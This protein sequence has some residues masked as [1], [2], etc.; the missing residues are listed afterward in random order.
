MKRMLSPPAPFQVT[1][2]TPLPTLVTYRAALRQVILNLI[3]NACEAMNEVPVESRLLRIV[4]RAGPRPGEIELS[5]ADRG[6]GIAPGQRERIFQPFITTKPDGLGLGLAICRSIVRAHGG[7]LWAETAERGAVFR[8][9]LR[10]SDLFT[11]ASA[12][13]QPDRGGRAEH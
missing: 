12:H 9:A 3:V 5:I 6:T 11:P 10:A 8:L 2:A 13:E 4:T 1:I 7:R